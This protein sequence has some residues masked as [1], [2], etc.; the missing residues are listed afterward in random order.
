MGL[1]TL[2]PKWASVRCTTAGDTSILRR[3]IDISRVLAG[4]GGNFP[5]A[6]TRTD[7]RRD[8]AESNADQH[9]LTEHACKQHNFYQMRARPFNK[10]RPGAAIMQ[11]AQFLQMK[12]NRCLRCQYVEWRAAWHE[13]GSL[14][15]SE[16]SIIIVANA[17]WRSIEKQTRTCDELSSKSSS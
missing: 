4:F 5:D 13:N 16:E 2:F 9:R 15:D 17:H 3:F 12:A 8:R 11:G 1:K 7:S 6:D 10:A 14:N